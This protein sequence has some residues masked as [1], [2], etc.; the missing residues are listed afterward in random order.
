MTDPAIGA[1]LPKAL[2]GL[3]A[4]AAEVSLDLEVR[5][6]VVAE[7]RHFLVG[8]VLD[9]RVC[10]EAELGERLLR[11]RETD[12][13]DVR[14][15]DLEALLVREV[16]SGDTCQIRLLALALLVT[17]IRADDHGPAVP[18]DHAAPLTHRLYGRS[19]LHLS[20]TSLLHRKRARNNRPARTRHGS[21][22]G[23]SFLVRILEPFSVTATVCSKCA[24]SDSS[25]VEIDHS[26]SWRYTADEPA[27]IIGS[28]ANRR[29]GWRIGPWPGSPKLG[30]RGSSCIW[31]PTP[32]PT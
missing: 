30:I 11:R 2:D 1:D 22:L 12:A 27:L 15:P 8:Q 24:D 25:S 13:V 18:L 20:N 26:S 5:V 23:S 17:W 19:D 7:L 21:K 31:R 32:W 29:P 9:L 28:I 16:H 10:R 4:L 3:R 14:E 6:D